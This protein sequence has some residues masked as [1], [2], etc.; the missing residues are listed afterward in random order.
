MLARCKD[1]AFEEKK[2]IP[3]P[4]AYDCSQEMGKKHSVKISKKKRFKKKVN[5]VPGPGQY[6][7]EHHHHHKSEKCGTYTYAFLK[8]HYLNFSLDFPKGRDSLIRRN[9]VQVLVPIN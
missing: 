7:H 3:G 9:T 5:D 8:A 6:D 2:L 4:G 1:L